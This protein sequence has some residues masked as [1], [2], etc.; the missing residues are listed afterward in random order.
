MTDATSTKPPITPVRPPRLRLHAIAKVW[1][2]FLIRGI[3]S[4]IFGVLTFMWPGLSLLTLVIFYGAFVLV[5]GIFA[6]I[7]AAQ[8]RGTEA[9][10]TWWLVLIGLAG[11]IAGAGTFFYPGLT[12]LLLVTFIGVW[13][14]VRGVFEIVGAIQMRKEI[15][16]EWWLVLSGIVSVLFGLIILIAPGPGAIGLAW[17]IGAFSLVIGVSL[18]A[19]SLRLRKHADH[20]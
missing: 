19:F 17:A 14:I 12:A 4:I 18:V 10:P 6:L 9:M 13:A 1:W 11:V 8:G 5:D 16:N 2:L 15:D 20:G 7:A 3:A